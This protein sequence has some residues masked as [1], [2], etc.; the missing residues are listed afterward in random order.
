MLVHVGLCKWDAIRGRKSKWS[1]PANLPTHP[2]G[3]TR[4]GAHWSYAEARSF[5]PANRR[6]VSGLQVLPNEAAN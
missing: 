3:A 5:R 2:E 6:F 4:Q 1:V